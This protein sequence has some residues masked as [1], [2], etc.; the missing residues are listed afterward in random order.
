LTLILDAGRT[1]S[2]AERGRNSRL[3]CYTVPSAVA[4]GLVLDCPLRPRPSTLDFDGESLTERYAIGPSVFYNL[5][6]GYPGR[7][8]SVLHA[9]K[10]CGGICSVEDAAQAFGARIEG[11]PCRDPGRTPVSI[12]SGRGKG[13][14]AVTEE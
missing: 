4:K 5:S 14:F 10:A 6:F 8:A 13:F 1:S 9:A 7:L 2:Q 3:H 11:R 12:V